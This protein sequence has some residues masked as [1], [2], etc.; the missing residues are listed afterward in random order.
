MRNFPPVRIP[1]SLSRDPEALAFFNE[2][3]NY[4]KTDQ[5]HNNATNLQGGSIN[6][7]YHFTSDEHTELLDSRQYAYLP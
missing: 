2:L 3:V 5:D 7:Y 4:L 1:A 6:E